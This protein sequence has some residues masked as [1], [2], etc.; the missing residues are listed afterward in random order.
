MTYM[1]L[2]REYSAL[3]TMHLQRFSVPAPSV[4]DPYYWASRICIR[5][6]PSSKDSKKTLISTLLWL[7]YDFFSLQN[8]ENVLV[9]R[10]WILIWIQIRMFLASRI[11]KSEVRIRE[12]GSAS[13]SVPKCHGSAILPAP[14]WPS[15]T[16]LQKNP[17]PQALPLRFGNN[18]FNYRTCS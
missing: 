3:Q 14:F 2:D 18:F 5:I 8:D 11:R 1:R 10:I 7:L 6:L 9:F 12:S 15:W 4:A 16:L 17:D 13:G